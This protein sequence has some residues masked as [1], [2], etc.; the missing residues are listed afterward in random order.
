MD[1]K[2]R[3]HLELRNRTPSDV[4]ELVLD[5]CRSNEGKIEGLTDEFEELEFLST[6]NVGLTTVAHLPKLKKLKKLE[7]SDNRI[8]GGLEVLAEKC[9]NLT[10]L[11]L[12]GNKIKDLSTIEPLKELGALKSL[13]LFNC[14]VTNLNEY[15]DNVFELL[16]QLTYLD[17]YDKD[18]KEAPDSDGEVYAEGLDDEEDDEDDVDEEEYDDDAPP[19]DEEDEEGE[20]DEEENEDDDEEEL[21]GEEEEEEDLNDREVDDE[22]DEEEE[23]GQKRKRDLDE[24]AEEDEDD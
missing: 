4:K 1:M 11:N 8:S 10:H 17:G 21:S 13:D 24:E 6:I 14:E 22:E 9:P 2:K 7:L 20:E 5:N 23:R 12:S 19:G 15:R 3:I 16:P 18:D